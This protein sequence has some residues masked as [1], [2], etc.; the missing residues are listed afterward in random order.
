MACSAKAAIR[1]TR[2]GVTLV[3]GGGHKSCFTHDHHE[4]GRDS[5]PLTSILSVARGDNC[6]RFDR[7]AV[8]ADPTSSSVACFQATGTLPAHH[9][10]AMLEFACFAISPRPL[11]V[12]C[13]P[14]TLEYLTPPSPP[15]NQSLDA[16][17]EIASPEKPKVESCD[18]VQAQMVSK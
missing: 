2:S 14:T 5:K 18:W 7:R 17:P 15:F 12:V 6:H 11:V 13:S 10:Q 8:K 3:L 4:P 16:R 1:F 9:H